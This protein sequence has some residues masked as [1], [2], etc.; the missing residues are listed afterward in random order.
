MKVLV[1][2]GGTSNERDVSLRSG[3]SVAEALR[4]KGHEVSEADP[5]DSNFD[6]SL[7]SQNVDVVFIAL[8]GQGGEDGTLQAQLEAIGKPFV[9]SGSE[10]S[11]LCIDKW[12]YKQLLINH[13]LPASEGW[14]VSLSEI[15]TDYFLKPYVLKPVEGGSSLDTQIARTPNENTKQESIEL[16]SKYEHMLLEPIIDGVEITIGILGDEPLP[17]IEIIPPLGLEF[18]YENKYNGATKELCPPQNV[19]EEVQNTARSL[20]LKI[21]NLT[22]C[23][24]MSR[25]DMIVDSH[26]QLH[27][28]ETNTIPGLTNQSLLPKMALEA[29]YSV[30]ELVNK[31]ITMAL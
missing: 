15:N 21:H 10:A 2:A 14:Q 6:I 26:D 13:G 12:A 30:P 17:V 23:R 25:T 24:H 27:V 19:K 5:R 3:K 1:I 8:H 18:D 31:L 9:G 28:L 11:R 4:Q 29:G 22:G 16:L 20:A 7:L